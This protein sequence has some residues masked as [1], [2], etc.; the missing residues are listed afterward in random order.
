M[1]WTTFWVDRKE[2]NDGR[3]VK[4]GSRVS[5]NEGSH[6]KLCLCANNGSNI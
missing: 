2:T 3:N 6:A 1:A 5:S 4:G